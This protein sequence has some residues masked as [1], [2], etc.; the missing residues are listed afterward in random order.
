MVLKPL[1]NVTEAAP[2][3]F[4]T[5][6]LMMGCSTIKDPAQSR[7]LLS[8]TNSLNTSC[9]KKTAIWWGFFRL[10]GSK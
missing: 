9:T 2:S 5:Y 3:I 10:K 8:M 6:W 4:S 7:K 1:K